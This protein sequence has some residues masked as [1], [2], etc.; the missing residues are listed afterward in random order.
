MRIIINRMAVQERPSMTLTNSC[1]H[2]LLAGEWAGKLWIQQMQ[3][4]P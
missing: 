4:W 3:G 1:L 2:P